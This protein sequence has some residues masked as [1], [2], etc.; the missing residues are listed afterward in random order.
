MV[1][2]FERIKALSMGRTLMKQFW[3]P[4]ASKQVLVEI[5]IIVAFIWPIPRVRI[6]L[7]LPLKQ[8]EK[9]KSKEKVDTPK[10]CRNL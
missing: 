9:A 3:S 6:Y 4:W 5:T 7:M 1:K 2:L 8:K 10:S